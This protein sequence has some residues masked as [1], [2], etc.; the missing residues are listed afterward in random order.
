MDEL[1]VGTPSSLALYGRGT[2][3]PF[4]KLTC[5]EQKTL[6]RLYAILTILKD[7]MVALKNG[8]YKCSIIQVSYNIED[9]V[10]MR[11]IALGRGHL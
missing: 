9:G 7:A 4:R 3:P 10:L 2:L 8:G 6:R 11:S 5:V 1:G